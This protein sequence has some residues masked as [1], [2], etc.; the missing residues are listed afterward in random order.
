VNSTLDLATVLS[1]IVARL[2]LSPHMRWA[3]SVK[4]RS[5]PGATNLTPSQSSS[6]DWS[7]Q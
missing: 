5:P 4:K 3:A 6:I 2:S 1:T 7:R